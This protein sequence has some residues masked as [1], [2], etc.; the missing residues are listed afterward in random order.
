MEHGC[1]RKGIA[2]EE[3]ARDCQWNREE[4]HGWIRHGRDPKRSMDRRARTASQILED[5]GGSNPT[6]T[7]NRNTKEDHA[8]TNRAGQHWMVERMP[9]D[10]QPK[11]RAEPHADKGRRNALH[12][13]RLCQKR[14]QMQWNTE[15]TKLHPM[16]DVKKRSGCSTR[17]TDPLS[18]P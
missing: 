1:S 14:W 18:A 17:T 16:R 11:N 3:L 12:D 7:M 13:Q 8:R 4:F 2:R 9:L 6:H 15:N 5:W 10:W